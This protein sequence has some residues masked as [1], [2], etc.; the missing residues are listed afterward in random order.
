MLPP[1]RCRGC[2]TF[3]CLC[4][5][6]A[7]RQVNGVAIA[8]LLAIVLIAERKFDLPIWTTTAV[9][10]SWAFIALPIVAYLTAHPVPA[11]FWGFWPD[12][13]HPKFHDAESLPKA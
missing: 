1:T 9:I 2:K 8:V 3:L 5:P 6:Q 10:L 11:K 4:E 13:R 12:R 7:V